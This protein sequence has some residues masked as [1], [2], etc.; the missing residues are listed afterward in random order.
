MAHWLT[1][2]GR[3]FIIFAFKLK[4]MAICAAKFIDDSKHAALPHLATVSA[5][6][7]YPSALCIF[8]FI[9]W[10]FLSQLKE[11]SNRPELNEMCVISLS[12]PQEGTLHFGCA[13][14]RCCARSG[15]A[16]RE[17][18]GGIQVD[19]ESGNAHG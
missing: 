6:S 4:E 10:H 5:G 18:R 12:L 3:L 11:N 8:Y 14:A 17:V 13:A 19:Q 7:L 2:Y 1:V 15:A 9:S 16:V